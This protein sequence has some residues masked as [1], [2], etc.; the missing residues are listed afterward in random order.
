MS[1]A[2]KVIE[3]NKKRALESRKKVLEYLKTHPCVDCGETDVRILEFDHVRGTK[4]KE[5]MGLIYR[6]S[7]KTVLKEIEK[8]DVRCA[9]CHRRRTSIQQGWYRDLLTEE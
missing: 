1:K 2:Q 4:K 6:Y 3:F 7:F 5:V 8:C 9:N